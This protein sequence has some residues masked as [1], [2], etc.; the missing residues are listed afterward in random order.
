MYARPSNECL[1]QL[2]YFSSYV[3]EKVGL[4]PTLFACKVIVDWTQVSGAPRSRT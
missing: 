3:E 4:E 1:D 2:D